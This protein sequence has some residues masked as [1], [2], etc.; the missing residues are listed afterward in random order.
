MSDEL[1]YIINSYLADKRTSR[2][3][4][5]I[6]SQFNCVI[7]CVTW[8]ER[9]RVS[10][11]TLRLSWCW[12]SAIVNCHFSVNFN[13]FL[14]SFN[15]IH[16]VNLTNFPVQLVRFP[17]RMLRDVQQF[18]WLHFLLWWR[19]R[20][21]PVEIFCHFSKSLNSQTFS[22]YLCR[23]WTSSGR[24]TLN[25][26]TDSMLAH[27]S[28]N[29][30]CFENSLRGLKHLRWNA[31]ASRA[32]F[33]GRSR[34]LDVLIVFVCEVACSFFYRKDVVSRSQINC[35]IRIIHQNIFFCSIEK[36]Q[37]AESKKNHTKAFRLAQKKYKNK[38]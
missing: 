23:V 8:C 25:Q 29:K 2:N 5:S 28:R 4:L 24:F 32:W 3:I 11:L 7:L 26:H 35:L 34:N 16:L 31:W 18:R 38:K 17:P 37:K 9:N 30:F 12:N 10:V 1:I 6:E 36:T 15:K 14:K 19:W 27:H 13:K 22:S 21:K 20:H 33:V